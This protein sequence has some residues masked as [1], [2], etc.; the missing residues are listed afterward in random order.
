MNPRSFEKIVEKPWGKEEWIANKEYCGK[1]ITI[2]KSNQT[3]FHYHKKKNETFYVLEGKMRI[4]MNNGIEKILKKEDIMD[5]PTETLHCLEAI[6]DCRILEISTHHDDTDSYRVLNGGGTLKAAILCGGKGERLKP[7]TYEMPKPLLPLSGKPMVEHILDLLK[8]YDVRDVTFAVGHLKEKIKNHFGDG[9]NYGIRASYIEEDNPLGTAGPLKCLEDRLHE[10]FI[11][12]NGDNLNNLDIDEMLIK[13]KQNNALATIAL[14]EVEN[15]SAYGVAKLD[16]E[17]ILEFI[18]KP[19][20][21]KEPSTFVNA[22]FYMLEPEIFK[23]I[24]QGFAML[25]R[26]VF[27][28]L[29]GEGRLYGYKFKGQWFDTGTLERYEEAIKNWRG[30]G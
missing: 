14:T 26:D 3:S 10:T 2:K 20:R 1:L 7:I 11:V 25:E 4:S 27:P 17:R 29:A 24:P 18:E 12:C 19:P 13:H 16:G 9:L 28:K 8:K 15:P 23:F 30:V 21:G 5:I 6:E 22:G